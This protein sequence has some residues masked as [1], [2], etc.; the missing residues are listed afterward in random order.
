MIE[1]FADVKTTDGYQ[2]RIFTIG[3]TRSRPNQAKKTSYAQ[4]A[5]VRR[6]RK[7]MVEIIQKEASAVDLSELVSKFVTEIIGK[8]I[9]KATQGIY[10][11]QNVFV[12]KVKVLRAPKTDLGKLLELHGGAGAAADSGAAVARPE[13]AKPAE[14]AKPAVSAK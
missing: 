11:L 14:A 12:R 5:Q 1:A 2:L 9:E 4:S 7:K 10:P 13:D 3:F 6:I 8:E